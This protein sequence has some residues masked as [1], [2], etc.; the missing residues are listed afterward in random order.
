MAAPLPF[1]LNQQNHDFVRRQ[2]WQA[3]VLPFGA[4]EPHNLHLPYGIDCFQVEAI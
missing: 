2:N 3:A 4:T 1:V